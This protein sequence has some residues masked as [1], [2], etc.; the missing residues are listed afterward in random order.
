MHG[1][2]ALAETV[3]GV[4][5]RL[6]ETHAG[7]APHGVQLPP[8]NAV[9]LGLV[10]YAE[11]CG[12]ARAHLDRPRWSAAWRGMRQVVG[13]GMTWLGG[14]LRLRTQDGARQEMLGRTL[15]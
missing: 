13:T 12:V 1:M 8:A 11:R 9:T 5:A 4:H 6:G 14:G 7:A 15:Q 3:F 2:L 10:D